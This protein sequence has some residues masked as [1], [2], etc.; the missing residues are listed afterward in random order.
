VIIRLDENQVVRR[1]LVVTGDVLARY[2]TTGTLTHKFQAKSRKPVAESC[3]V[4][5]NDTPNVQRRMRTTHRRLLP[6]TKVFKRLQSLVGSAIESAGTDQERNR[7]AALHHAVSQRLGAVVPDS[8]QFPDILDQL[9]EV[10]LQTAGTID[11]GLVC[12]D[13][14][15]PLASLPGFQ[16]CDVRYAVFYGT[17]SGRTVVIDHVVVSTGA[18][19]FVF[20]RRFE[21]KIK[22]T[23]I[24]LHLPS[25]FF[26]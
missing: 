25:D 8:G 3:L 16:H 12:P 6:I 4:S 22:N 9:V 26:S 2:D 5:A 17:L 18:A 15:E 20:F 10:K 1:V 11:L 23:K 7:G 19:F 24:Q 14:T 13:S 21:G